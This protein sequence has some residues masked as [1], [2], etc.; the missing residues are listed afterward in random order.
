M[1]ERANEKKTVSIMAIRSR[2]L[3]VSTTRRTTEQR[4]SIGATTVVT[5]RTIVASVRFR[6]TA[7]DRR[8]RSPGLESDGRQGM[9]APWQINNVVLWSF[10]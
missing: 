4:G 3:F 1:S 2:G 7:T 10:L 6:R 8:R 9:R 5:A